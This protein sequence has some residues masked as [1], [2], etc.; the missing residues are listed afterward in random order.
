MV[1][2]CEELGCSEDWYA[3]MLCPVHGK[4]KLCSKHYIAHINCLT[5]HKE[6]PSK[7]RREST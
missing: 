5:G 6:P 7:E 1:T 4:L 3:T 2:K